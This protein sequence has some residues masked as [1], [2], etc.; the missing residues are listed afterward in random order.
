MIFIGFMLMIPA[1]IILF[2]F[3]ALGFAIFN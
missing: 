2:A 1:K 3:A